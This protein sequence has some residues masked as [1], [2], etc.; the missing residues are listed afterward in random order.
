MFR[1]LVH[2]ELRS[3]ARI[4]GALD[5]QCQEPLEL[6]L[7]EAGGQVSPPALGC[8]WS[9]FYSCW[10]PEL[11]PEPRPCKVPVC[12]GSCPGEHRPFPAG[13]GAGPGALLSP[14]VRGSLSGTCMTQAVARCSFQMKFTRPFQHPFPHHWPLHPSCIS[15]ELRDAGGGSP[16]KPTEPCS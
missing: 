12:L 15:T 7:Q 5:K 2:K 11:E 8:P 13:C 3:R 10:K 1:P 16:S 6:C 4:W 14:A 9:Y